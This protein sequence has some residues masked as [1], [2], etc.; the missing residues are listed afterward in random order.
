M[1]EAGRTLAELVK[2]RDNFTFYEVQRLQNS[3]VI[4]LYELRRCSEGRPPNASQLWGSD[5]I[6]V[7]A[8]EILL[9]VKISINNICKVEELTKPFNCID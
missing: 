3:W 1:L 6:S 4:I 8:T 7:D 2:H 9:Q 5:E